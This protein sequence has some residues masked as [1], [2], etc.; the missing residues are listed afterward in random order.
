[1]S[2]LALAVLYILYW[3]LRREGTFLLTLNGEEQHISTSGT[4]T[5]N[6]GIKK[7]YWGWDYAFI[8]TEKGLSRRMPIFGFGTFG[9]SSDSRS[10]QNTDQKVLLLQLENDEYVVLLQ[11][12]LPWEDVKDLN[13]IGE[14]L[15]KVEVQ[16]KMYLTGNFYRFK[17]RLK[18]LV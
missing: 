14:L 17:K 12:C 3:H 16:H 18:G 5:L 7:M 2:A 13:Y 9:T 10:L 8:N 4:I 1:V 11:E 6:H 15:E